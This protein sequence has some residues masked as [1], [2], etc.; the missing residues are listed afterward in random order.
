MNL[1]NHVWVNSELIPYQSVG[2]KLFSPRE[3]DKLAVVEDLECYETDMGL[4]VSYLEEHVSNFIRSVHMLGYEPGYR[5]DEICEVVTKTVQY[6]RIQDGCVRIAMYVSETGR[7]G[8]PVM[9]IAACDWDFI[10]AQG[11]DV[12]RK[13]LKKNQMITEP[14][15]QVWASF[16][17]P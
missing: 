10:E 14:L 15:S 12:K 9:A 16:V 3:F 4:A 5:F 17:G 2:V 1:V 11:K 13:I 8:N 6:N 7:K